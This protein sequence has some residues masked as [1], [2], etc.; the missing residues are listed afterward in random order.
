MKPNPRWTNSYRL[1]Y[2][3]YAVLN[4]EFGTEV[5]FERDSLHTRYSVNRHG[6]KVTAN[7]TPSSTVRTQFIKHLERAGYTMDG[8]STRD[9]LIMCKRTPREDRME[10]LNVSI[11]VDANKALIING[12]AY[13]V[14]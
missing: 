7:T 5:K 9:F 4:Y 12:S 11:R 14:W 2:W 3:L 13:L 10:E 6:F 1:Q 8:Q